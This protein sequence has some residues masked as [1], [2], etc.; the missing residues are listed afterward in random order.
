MLTPLYVSQC[1]KQWTQNIS[2]LPCTKNKHANKHPFSVLTTHIHD[3]FDL[4]YED[5]VK[6][7]QH[8]DWIYCLRW[9]VC[10]SLFC[11][12]SFLE[13]LHPETKQLLSSTSKKK[14][15]S[16]NKPA[17]EEEPKGDSQPVNI[18]L[19]FKRYVFDRHK[20]MVQSWP[21][22]HTLQADT[23]GDRDE[24]ASEVL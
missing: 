22:L 14:G 15:K 5:I 17:N 1:V 16:G 20:K 8:M 23:T 10:M 2:Y 19:H 18:H 4:I 6:N 24:A 12:W 3:L 11:C 21:L 7:S 13:G 9:S